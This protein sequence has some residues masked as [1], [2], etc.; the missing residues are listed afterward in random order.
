MPEKNNP[1]ENT[2]IQG[3]RVLVVGASGFIGSALAL[4]LCTDANEVY[5]LARFRD[6]ALREQLESAG[7]HIIQKD[8]HTER[9][10]DL[11]GD[12]DYVFSELAMLRN[13]D[14]NPEE[15]YD[16]NSYFV[17]RLMQHCRGTSGV[18]LASTGAVY[19]PGP[20]PWDENGTIGPR[21]AYSMSKFGGEVLGRFLC[22]L[23]QIPTCILRYFY[24]YGPTGGIIHRWVRQIAAGEEILMNRS[25]VPRYN[26]IY[27][28][29]CIRC[30][31]D[32]AGLCSTPARVINI[33]GS[34]ELSQLQLITIISQMLGM[35]PKLR[36]TEEA[37]LFWVGDIGLMNRLFGLPAVAFADGIAKVVQAVSLGTG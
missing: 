12:F 26:P 11:P 10:D 33:G 18:V 23:W 34:E 30:T 17:G 6:P 29:D 25:Y 14:K 27:I 24:P 8:I 31:I 36:E 22:E 13:C 28:S 1:N 37:P 5:G 2:S 16:V 20:H 21:N 7:V 4:Q 32:A 9:I 3:K 15:A 35:E 19:L